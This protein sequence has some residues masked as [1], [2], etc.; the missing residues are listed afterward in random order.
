MGDLFVDIAQYQKTA[1][2]LDLDCRCGWNL[3]WLASMGFSSL[4]GADISESALDAMSEFEE[5]IGTRIEKRRMD[6]YSERYEDIKF[7]VIFTQ[8]GRAHV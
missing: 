2:I 7:D 1:P 5:I 8:I 6:F 4:Y 3:L